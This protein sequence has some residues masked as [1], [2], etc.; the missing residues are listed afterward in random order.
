[1]LVDLHFL[2][3]H[4]YIFNVLITVYIFHSSVEFMESLTNN[5]L[6]Q[7][8]DKGEWFY[9]LHCKHLQFLILSSKMLLTRTQQLITILSHSLPLPPLPRGATPYL[10][11]G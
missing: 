10:I 11:S 1:M 3:V 7:I 2:A 8:L 4:D 6:F 5:L 9:Q